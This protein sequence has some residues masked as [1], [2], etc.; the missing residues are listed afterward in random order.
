MAPHFRPQ[1]ELDDIPAYAAR[2]ES[3]DDAR[4]LAIGEAARERGCYTRAG[5]VEVCRWKTP[6]SAPLVVRN[7]AAEVKAVTRVA[8]RDGADARDRMRAQRTLHGVDWPTASVL[9]HVTC[10]DS[11]PILDVRVL[12]ALGVPVATYGYTFWEAFVSNHRA[13]VTRVGV[14]G[15]TLD[16]G[17]WQWSAVQR[18]PLHGNHHRHSGR[19]A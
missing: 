2:Y 7:T 16:R 17:M 3:E 5:F 6:R 19:R 18:Q 15:R 1:F 14:D 10:P 8:L 4:V 9:L 12:E 11:W 13:L